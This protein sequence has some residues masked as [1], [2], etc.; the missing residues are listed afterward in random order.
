MSSKWERRHRVLRCPAEVEEQYAERILH[1][2]SST[3]FQMH[4]RI[5]VSRREMRRLR[6]LQG[7]ILDRASCVCSGFLRLTIP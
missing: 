1:R 2:W 3:V 7:A 6:P 4:R 5:L